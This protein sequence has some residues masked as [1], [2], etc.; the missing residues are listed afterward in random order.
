MGWLRCKV[1]DWLREEVFK[2]ELSSIKSMKLQ[3]EN[4]L[5][6]V[7]EMKSLYQQI[8]NVGVDVDYHGKNSWAVICID[9]HSEYVKFVDLKGFEARDIENFLRRFEKSN[10]VVDSPFRINCLNHIKGYELW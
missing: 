8:T 2:E 6:K 10:I 7:N 5:N 4:T 1:K 3:C 9:G